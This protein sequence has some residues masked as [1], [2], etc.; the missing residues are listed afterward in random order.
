MSLR[1]LITKSTNRENKGNKQDTIHITYP[2]DSG[3]QGH[4]DSHVLGDHG[5]RTQPS[6]NIKKLTYSKKIS[7]AIKV[8]LTL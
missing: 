5:K 2:W 8:F 3:T 4:R 1:G 7:I 6:C